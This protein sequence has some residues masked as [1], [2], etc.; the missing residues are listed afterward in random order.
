MPSLEEA[1][2]AFKAERDRR[3]GSKHPDTEDRRALYAKRGKVDGATWRD[4]KKSPARY[5]T[6]IGSGADA[7]QLYSYTDAELDVAL[8]LQADVRAANPKSH[9]TLRKR[10]ATRAAA[11]ASKRAKDVEIHG[12]H[13]DRERR[14]LNAVE[15]AVHAPPLAFLVLML[16][17][18]ADALFRTNGMPKDRYI[19]EQH[20]TTAKMYTH[21]NGSRSYYF[22]Q[23]TGY[24]G[25]VVFECEVDGA[26][27]VARGTDV[28]NVAAKDGS[29]AITRDKK[30]DAPRLGKR[31]GFAYL[32]TGE[33][34]HAALRERLLA[35]CQK[36]EDE[37]SNALPL[38]TMA[39]ANAELSPQ[40]NVEER[41]I[42][43][44]IRHVCGGIA[45]GTVWAGL[46]K[47]MQRKPHIYMPINGAE[48]VHNLP[49]GAP[50]DVVAYPEG[51]QN[52][53]ADLLYFTKA[54]GYK[55]CFKLQ[56]KTAQWIG[57]QNG[58]KVD[59][60][61]NDGQYDGKKVVSNTYRKGHNDFYVAVL[62]PESKSGTRG[63]FHCWTF[64]EAKMLEKNYIGD[65]ARDSFYV[66]KKSKPCAR[67]G[68]VH[69]WTVDAHRAF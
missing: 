5:Q 47:R 33:A 2:A 23:V 28:D 15:R 63:E 44:W 27:F 11:N 20:K 17:S 42:R 59:M 18:R 9:S 4:T 46:P 57:D 10:K 32:G 35:E 12:D 69:A 36:V 66:Y 58:F 30:T 24:K 34:A 48:M 6:T 3:K 43:G 21:P 51:T 49:F 41:G 40:A 62:P 1:V 37:A 52:G 53:K 65:H 19:A 54:S 26:V 14:M 61:S 8:K 60:R 56:F 38:Y 39:Q 68:A 13:D 67:K 25:L 7:I 64:S 45:E 31:P 16:P 29:L 55:Q 50:G 22:A